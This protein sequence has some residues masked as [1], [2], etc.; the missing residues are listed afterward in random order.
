LGTL[1]YAH[2]DEA[3][4]QP[5]RRK[6]NSPGEAAHG[7]LSIDRAQDDLNRD[8]SEVKTSEFFHGMFAFALEQVGRAEDALSQGRLGKHAASPAHQRYR[9]LDV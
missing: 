8:E 6:L 2:S 5:K 4:D 1:L 9:G 3:S 7:A